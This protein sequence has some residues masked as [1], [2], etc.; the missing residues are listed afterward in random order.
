MCLMSKFSIFSVFFILAG[1]IA[2]L[3]FMLF[4]ADIVV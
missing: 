4:F 2:E 3:L 1:W